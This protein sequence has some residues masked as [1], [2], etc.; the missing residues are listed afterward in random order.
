[1][2]YGRDDLRLTTC[3]FASGIYDK[4][5]K[6]YHTAFGSTG[7]RLYR[8]QGDTNGTRAFDDW[9]DSVRDAHWG[10]GSTFLDVDLDGDVDLFVTNGYTLP[11]SAEEDAHNLTCVDMCT[12]MRMRIG[13]GSA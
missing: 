6:D 3:D 11:E 5:P 12:G 9:S 1:M 7:N 4:R 2:V 8:N 10:W 13:R